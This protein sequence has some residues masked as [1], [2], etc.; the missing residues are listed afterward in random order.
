MNLKSKAFLTS[1][2]IVFSMTVLLVFLCY[3]FVD[4][5]VST[6]VYEK[7]L[8]H[9]A[10]LNWFAEI[11]KYIN[12]IASLSLIYFGVKRLWKKGK[13]TEQALLATALS[14]IFAS[15]ITD[16]SKAFFGRYWP[17]TWI[18]N[19]PSWIQNK[20]YGFNFFHV[21]W[22]YFSFPSGHTA[23]IVAVG[24]MIWLAFPKWRLLS[25]LLI[26]LEVIG[27]IGMNF[28]FVGDVVGG[29]FIGWLVALFVH[30]YVVPTRAS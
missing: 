27:L 20:V 24:T 19:N 3:F 6:W 29:A 15:V 4:R 11:A 21:G 9:F 12:A 28:H 8:H 7:K 17:E 23:I 22:G 10:F 26:I 25:L 2:L 13:I 14:S 5:E 30:H 16:S 1:L 18:Q